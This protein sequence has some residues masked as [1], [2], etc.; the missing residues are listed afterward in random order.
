M[1]SPVYVLNQKGRQ[2]LYLCIGLMI[3]PVYV[4]NQK[5]RQLYL[6]IGLII[7]TVLKFKQKG[8]QMILLLKRCGS[9]LSFFDGSNITFDYISAPLS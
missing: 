5:G 6:C 2:L 7:P 3:S 9:F 1:I 4:L 8:K